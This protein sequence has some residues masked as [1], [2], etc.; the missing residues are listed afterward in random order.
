MD[1]L[2]QQDLERRLAQRLRPERVPGADEPW[3][4]IA[5]RLAEARGLGR[6]WWAPPRVAAVLAATIALALVTSLVL[7]LAPGWRVGEDRLRSGNY[8]PPVSMPATVSEVEGFR[9]TMQGQ[10]GGLDYQVEC[11]RPVDTRRVSVTMRDGQGTS[12]G[13]SFE[14]ACADATQVVGRGSLAIGPLPPGA[15]FT[16]TLTVATVG[17]AET[18]SVSG[19]PQA[20]L[21]GSEN[22]LYATGPRTG[23]APESAGVE[24]ALT[25]AP[26]V[27]PAVAPVAI[28]GSG[29]RPGTLVRVEVVR[30]FAAQSGGDR[31]T[32]G[33]G[34]KGLYAAMT[35]PVAADGRFTASIDTADFVAGPYLV[36]IIEEGGG[37]RGFVN[38]TV[39]TPGAAPGPTPTAGRR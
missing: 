5:P 20:Y 14:S 17:P 26:N 8:G 13:A 6:M 11:L 7:A 35:A 37:V 33:R 27:A 30:V 36:N 29:F 16:L 25:V 15:A 1:D 24:R 39:S 34:D 12:G 31:I 38:F 4:R 32:V 28:A 10:S 2:R 3:R 22:Q 18:T 9:L 21:K 19:S 23:H